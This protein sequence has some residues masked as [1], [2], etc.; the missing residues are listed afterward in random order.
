MGDLTKHWSTFEYFPRREY[1]LYTQ[2]KLPLRVLD[3]RL[4]AADE[5]F[6][7]RYGKTYINTWHDGG[8]DEFCGFRPWDCLIG[9]KYS[10]HRTGRASDKRPQKTT[11]QE[12]ADDIRKRPEILLAMGYTA[13][14]DP[15]Y[16]QGWIHGEVGGKPTGKLELVKP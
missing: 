11:W 3:Y 7:V 5:L 16:T 15:D 4:I 6:V 10:Q 13:V 1:Q 9:A 14:E 12:I 2:G 8:L